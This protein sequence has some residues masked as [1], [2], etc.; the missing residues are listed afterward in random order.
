MLDAA[1]RVFDDLLNIEV[2]TLLKSGMT[3]RKMPAIGHAF[4]DIYGGYDGWL[5]A[6]GVELNEQW[7]RFRTSDGAEKFRVETAAAG[8]SD[9]WWV[10]VDEQL[11]DQ[12]VIAPPLEGVANGV[13]LF[14]E[15]RNRARIAEEMHRLLEGRR[16]YMVRDGGDVMLKRIVRNCDQLKAILE[17]AAPDM[18]AELSRATATGFTNVDVDSIPRDDLIMIRKAWDIGT[19][20]VAMQTVVQLD[21]DIVTR[22]NSAYAADRHQP[23]R[24]LHRESVGSAL[25]HW[26]YLVETLVTI[27][28]STVSGLT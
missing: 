3:G 20:V 24:D 21:G 17:R 2:N 11:V 28:K 15:M 9:R 10:I 8:K 22:L 27:V 4:L 14:E 16:G 23:V 13:E 26:R 1:K 25:E 6:Y 7:S 5:N 18:T 12:L 19:E